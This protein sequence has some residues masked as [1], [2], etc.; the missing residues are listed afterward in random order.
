MVL[1]FRVHYVRIKSLLFWVGTPF[2]DFLPPKIAPLDRGNGTFNS[3]NNDVVE[4]VYLLVLLHNTGVLRWRKDAYSTWTEMT[5][6]VSLF[7]G[8]YF[9][10]DFLK[11][12]ILGFDENVAVVV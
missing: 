8:V 6:F 12:E 9:L 4:N 7:T 2:W 11:N 1:T 10:M 5:L 3:S